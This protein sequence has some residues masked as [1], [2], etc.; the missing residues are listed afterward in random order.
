MPTCT[1][2]ANTG[3]C[4]VGTADLSGEQA[5][6]YNAKIY[7]TVSSKCAVIYGEEN[8]STGIMVFQKTGTT[9]F[10]DYREVTSTLNS[11]TLNAKEYN[12]FFAVYDC[13]T[14]GC[15]QTAGFVRY[16]TESTPATDALH[17]GYEFVTC[18]TKNNLLTNVIGCVKINED[19]T[20]LYSNDANWK[21]NQAK[22]TSISTYR[23]KETA[24]GGIFH[25]CS[26]PK[27]G[28][29]PY[30][31]K[32][33]S[34]NTRK[35]LDDYF[36]FENGSTFFPDTDSNTKVFLIVNEYSAVLNKRKSLKKKIKIKF[37]YYF[38][39]FFCHKVFLNE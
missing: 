37:N 22:G 24:S 27:I 3:A 20:P 11:I 38:L 13:T 4:K 30:D 28:E 29:S 1:S 6:I 15:I 17:S 12:P 14:S 34:I 35:G 5:C 21:C 33:I 2:Y 23:Y 19:H 18:Y 39:Y 32:Y 7:M 16:K 8:K 10:T 25:S 36:F 31:F 26:A 9:S